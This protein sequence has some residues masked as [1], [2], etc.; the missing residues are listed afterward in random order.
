MATQVDDPVGAARQLVARPDRLDDAVACKQAAPGNLPA[1]V[2]EAK[3]HLGIAKEQ[4]T[5][6]A[7]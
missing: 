3:Q 2:I 7:Q 1:I 6:A 4:R 5:H